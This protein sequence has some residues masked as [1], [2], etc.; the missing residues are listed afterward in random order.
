LFPR[1]AERLLHENVSTFSQ[2]SLRDLE[3]RRRVGRN[4]DG[5][6]S[7]IIENGTQIGHGVNARIERGHRASDP[8]VAIADV[9]EVRIRKGGIVA[10]VVLA[11]ATGPD[12]CDAYRI[13]SAHAA[14]RF[15]RAA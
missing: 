1:E 9:A 14:P 2:G 5:F 4:D 7:G 15:I 13:R 8:V 6:D 11:P 10:N 12:D 3:M